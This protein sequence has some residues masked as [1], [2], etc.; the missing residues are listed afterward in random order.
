MCPGHQP[1]RTGSEEP[2]TRRWLTSILNSGA[3]RCEAHKV[4][5]KQ[6]FKIDVSNKVDCKDVYIQHRKAWQRCECVE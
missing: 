3:I 1:S 2:W 6:K 5:S 4:A